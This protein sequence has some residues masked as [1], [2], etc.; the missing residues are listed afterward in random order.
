LSSHRDYETEKDWE[1][2]RNDSAY[3]DALLFE[4]VENDGTSSAEQKYEMVVTNQW[5][6]KVC[7]FPFGVRVGDVDLALAR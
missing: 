7:W 3:S 4:P 2:L 5:S 6:S 1:W